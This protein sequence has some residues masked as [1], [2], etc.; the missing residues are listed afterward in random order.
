MKVV[1][2]AK[3]DSQESIFRKREGGG[4]LKKFLFTY[5]TV[6]SLIWIG[7]GVYALIANQ[8]S[9][10]VIL[11]FGIA[12]S[13]CLF[14]ASWFSSWIMRHYKRIDSMAKTMFTKNN[15]LRG[16]KDGK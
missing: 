2:S 4:Y 8:P 5:A 12:F 10:G 16:V 9:S 7:Y 11:G 1:K 15:K 3:C 6:L 14:I 13:V